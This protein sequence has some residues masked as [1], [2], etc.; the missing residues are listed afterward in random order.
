VRSTVQPPRA[1]RADD[2]AAAISELIDGVVSANLGRGPR[3]RTYVNGTVIT[4][5]LEDALTAGELRLVREG[6]R[7]SVLSTRR[8]LQRTLREELKSGLERITGRRVRVSGDRM[9]PS[10]AIE[11][12]VLGDRLGLAPGLPR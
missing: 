1:S 4:L 2:G 8:A 6:L 9:T 7:E 5:V 11:V 10:V 3:V 12:L